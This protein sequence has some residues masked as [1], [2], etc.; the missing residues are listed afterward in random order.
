M[1][2]F[3]NFCKSVMVSCLSI[4]QQ[5]ELAILEFIH[6]L[7]ETLD[8]YFANVVSV[9]NVVNN[10]CIH[11]CWHWTLLMHLKHLLCFLFSVSWMY[12]F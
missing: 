9:R 8:R 11:Y 12:P 2:V 10:E 7:V 6:N 3:I 5:N 4:L 1:L